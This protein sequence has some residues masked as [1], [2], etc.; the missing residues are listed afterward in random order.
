MRSWYVLIALLSLMFGTIGFADAQI[1]DAWSFGTLPSDGVVS[2]QAGTTVGWGYTLQNESPTYWLFGFDVQPDKP[3]QHGLGSNAPFDFP[4][5]APGTSVSVPYDGLVGL[6]NL[7]W[8]ADAPV[9]F[10]N[11]GV[12]TLTSYWYDGDPFVDGNLV[13]PAGTRQSPY[14]AVVNPTI[15]TPEPGPAALMFGLVIPFIGW[16]YWHRFRHKQGRIINRL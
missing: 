11:S 12:F 15:S 4:V 8:D 2:G 14:S 3:F 16:A 1:I 9:G 5:L 6:V 7:Q 10:V 13:G